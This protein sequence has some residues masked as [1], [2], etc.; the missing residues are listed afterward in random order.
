MFQIKFDKLTHIKLRDW[1]ITANLFLAFLFVTFSTLFV[2]GNFQSYNGDFGQYYIH[3][4]NLLKDRPWS[5]SVE[6]YPAVLPLYPY[7][8]AIITF[9]FGTNFFFYALA[10]SI[11][12]AIT[13]LTWASIYKDKLD[14]VATNLLYLLFILFTPFIVSFQQEGQPNI[15]FAMFCAFSVKAAIQ[16]KNNEFSLVSTILILLPA[17]VRVESIALFSAYIAYFILNRRGIFSLIAILGIIITISSDLFI[18]SHL[19]MKSNFGVLSDVN[20]NNA[21][22]SNDHL[23]SIATSFLHLVSSYFLGFGEMITSSKLA[24]SSRIILDFSQTRILSTSYLHFLILVVFLMGI[25]KKGG[26]LSLDLLFFF[27]LL[28]LISL[29]PLPEAPIRY[30]LP[31]VPIFGFYFIFALTKATQSIVKSG[32][33][34]AFFSFLILLPLLYS[35]LKE[36]MNEPQRRNFL[37]N[38]YTI[39]MADWVA[40]HRNG[41]GIGFFKPRLMTVLMDIRDQNNAPDYL[42]RNIQMADNLIKQQQL[43]VVFNSGGYGQKEILDHLIRS[44]AAKVLWKNASFTVFGPMQ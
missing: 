13:C 37:Y 1:S 31:L 7:L 8:L 12:W 40:E 22:R 26:I 44:S 2:L 14:S 30:L 39:E 10:N 24:E 3:A 33:F 35:S 41:R 21:S 20:Q 11:M 38:K 27:S 15:M 25:L 5:Y 4:Q 42:L 16:L 19:G 29:F 17:F 43:V 6:G 28:G 36:E 32:K 18:G 34:S 23:A 9:F